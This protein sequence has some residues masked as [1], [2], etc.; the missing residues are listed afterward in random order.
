MPFSKNPRKCDKLAN[1]ELLPGGHI[2]SC[3]ICSNALLAEYHLWLKIRRRCHSPNDK[4]YYCY[5]AKGISMC[6]EWRTSFAEFYNYIGPQPSDDYTLKRLDIRKDY[7]PGNV[8]WRKIGEPR[9]P[10]VVPKYLR[11]EYNIW[12]G[13]VQRCCNEKCDAWDK[14]GGR[15]ITICDRWRNS[16]DAFLED[17]GPRPSKFHSVDRIDVNGNYE[18]SNCRWAT[19][20][21]Q[22][23]NM[24]RNVHIEYQGRKMT[25][26]EFS[27][28]TD[29]TQK[30][31]YQRIKDGITGEALIAPNHKTKTYYLNGKEY[32]T[33]ELAQLSTVPRATITLR[34]S[35][36]WDVEKAV[37]QPT[38]GSMV[39]EY[40]GLWI[41]IREMS[42]KTGISYNVLQT[43]I[44]KGDTGSDV[45]RPIHAPKK[46]GK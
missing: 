30:T 12:E 5:G 10:D 11:S 36:G 4:N 13:I 46:N 28:L 42:E 27:E 8:S 34:L 15:G 25:I 23:R 38:Q 35:D 19:Q 29:V 18:P 16:S 31:M 37:F 33:R 2:V 17:M 6:P 40:E 9:N 20:K 43:R 1:Y 21:E 22:M 32:T 45:Y 41:T 7:E 26:A 14:Y 39:Y 3:E 44:R 24:R